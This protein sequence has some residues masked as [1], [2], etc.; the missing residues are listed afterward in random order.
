[1]SWLISVMKNNYD[2]GF[3]VLKNLNETDLF[4]GLIKFGTIVFNF[5]NHINIFKMVLF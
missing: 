2:L 4:N 3:D 5:S 1:M